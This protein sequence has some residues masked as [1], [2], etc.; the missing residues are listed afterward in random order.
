MHILQIDA[1]ISAAYLRYFAGGTG[2]A[3]ELSIREMHDM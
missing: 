1:V 3:Q 2:C